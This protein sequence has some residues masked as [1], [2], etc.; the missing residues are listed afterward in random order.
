[1]CLHHPAPFCVSADELRVLGSLRILSAQLRDLHGFERLQ[2]KLHIVN[3]LKHERR[4]RDPEP[5]K[6]IFRRLNLLK[7]VVDVEGELERLGDK[8]HGMDSRVVPAH[9]LEIRL[10]PQPLI[11]SVFFRHHCTQRYRSV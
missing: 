10:R 7:D 6:L 8:C 1:M 3:V 11:E 4:W 9:L 5:V 2:I